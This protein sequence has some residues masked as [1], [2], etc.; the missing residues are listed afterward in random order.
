MMAL[1][2]ISRLCAVMNAIAWGVVKRSLQLT[3]SNREL[4]ERLTI[5]DLCVA[6]EES[7]AYATFRNITRPTRCY[8]L[9]SM[10]GCCGY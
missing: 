6:T 9:P 4:P 5:G 8:D 1:I 2:T 10:M 7:P 3:C